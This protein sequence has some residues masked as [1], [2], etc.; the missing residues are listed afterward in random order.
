MMK[1]K[2]GKTITVG[3]NGPQ[4]SKSDVAT[5]KAGSAPHFWAR[6]C[7]KALDDGLLC[8]NK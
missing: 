8:G 2:A 4:M 7:L 3:S 1:I 5:R 6:E